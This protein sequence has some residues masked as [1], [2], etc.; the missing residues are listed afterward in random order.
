MIAVREEVRQIL[1]RVRGWP[2]EDRRQLAEEIL[3]SLHSTPVTA[4]RSE[5][6]SP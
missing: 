2:P 5:H 3:H 4:K 6:R 1:E